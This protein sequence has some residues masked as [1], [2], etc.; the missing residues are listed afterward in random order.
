MV[1][2]SDRGCARQMA[3]CVACIG[4]GAPKIDRPAK[5]GALLARISD[6]PFDWLGVQLRSMVVVRNR[7]YRNT[8]MPRGG[9]CAVIA[10]FASATVNHNS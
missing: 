4:M 5:C 3:T 8:A 1:N 7:R 10:S 2:S 6:G 9:A